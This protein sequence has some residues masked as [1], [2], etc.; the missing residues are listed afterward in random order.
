MEGALLRDGWWERPRECVPGGR[1]GKPEPRSDGR[2]CGWH[3]RHAR[4]PSGATM[5][6]RARRGGSDIRGGV[7]RSGHGKQR[8]GIEGFPAKLKQWRRVVTTYDKLAA[9]FLGFIKLVTIRRWLR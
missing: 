9:N 4:P 5:L 2:C 1:E 6:D 8:R 7:E 3:V